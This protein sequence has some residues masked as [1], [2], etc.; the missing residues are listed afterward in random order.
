MSQRSEL[1]RKSRA[2]DRLR[3]QIAAVTA[4]CDELRATMLEQARRATVLRARIRL[5]DLEEPLQ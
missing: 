5:V 1:A 4:E 2:A 3:E